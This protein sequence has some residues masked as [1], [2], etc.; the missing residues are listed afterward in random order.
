MSSWTANNIPDQTGKIAIV[1]GANSGIGFETA[2]ALAAKNAT[3]IMA[4]RNSDKAEAAM[5]EIK[6]II[7]EAKLEFIQLDLCDLAS[8]KAFVTA[9]QDRHHMLDLLINNAGIM[10]PPYSKTKDG[11]EVQFGANHLGH[12]ALTGLL[13]PIIQA[14]KGTRVVNVS[15]GAHRMGTGTINFDDLNAEKGYSPMRSYAQSKLANL[16]FTRQLNTYFQSENIKALVTSAHPGWTATNL[17]AYSL[18]FRMLNPLF[19]QTPPMG[20]LPTLYAATTERKANDYAGPGGWQEMRG[21]PKLVEMSNSAK[22]A[23]LAK[24]LWDVSEKLTGVQ[25]DSQK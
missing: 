6:K 22:D 12:F 8:V 16:L 18:P 19:A 21:Y 10:M 13:M 24:H 2:K 11:F 3:V 14:T 20:A 23:A 17:Q 5:A 1:T 25:Y 7:H 4:C 15:S 9:F